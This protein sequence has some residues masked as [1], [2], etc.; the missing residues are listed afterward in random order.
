[1]NVT[2]TCR[3]TE[4][5]RYSICIFIGSRANL[6]RLCYLYEYLKNNG[7][8]SVFVVGANTLNKIRHNIHIDF[9]IDTD[10][11]NDTRPNR[12]TTIGLTSIMVSNWLSSQKIDMCI[13]HGD[14][15]ETLGFAIAANMNSIPMLHL[16]A[17]EISNVDNDQRWA[18]SALSQYHG[19]H[20]IE[21]QKN[22]KFSDRSFLV[23]NP[24]VDYIKS[25]EL[26]KP[27]ESNK[28]V[29]LYNPSLSK[30]E[31]SLFMDA[32]RNLKEQHNFDYVWVNPNIDPGNKY[33]VKQAK[34]LGIKFISNLTT[35]E[36]LRLLNSACCLIGN[37]SSGIKEAYILEVPFILYGNRQGD[38]QVFANTY[39]TN[40]LSGIIRE[41]IDA[42]VTYMGELGNGDACIKISNL[43]K[44]V[45][46]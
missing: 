6:G 14:R 23:G 9:Y 15:Y 7:Q 17:G 25:L 27:K 29:I 18:I 41:A 37:T 33:I 19:C 46:Y 38:R 43:I 24:V 22:L 40:D 4:S 11:H 12:A 30:I 26:D 28:V 39:T 21:A 2:T 42:G 34:Q 3:T 5:N 13:C 1:V 44:E 35:E 10:M 8:F 20:T 16:E 31:T 36:Y 32:I 45:L